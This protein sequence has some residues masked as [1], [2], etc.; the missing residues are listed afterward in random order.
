MEN[1]STLHGLGGS[2]G[3]LGKLLG[4]HPS[5][6]RSRWGRP[7]GFTL[8]ELL[9]VIAI[10]AI[11]AAMLLPVLNKA[12]AK[13]QS[14]T[15]LNNL[16][17]LQLAWLMYCEDSNDL[18]PLNSSRGGHGVAQNR[19]GSWVV[20]NAPRSANV[21]SITQGTL[22]PQ[23]Q[24]PGSYRCPADRS[25]ILTNQ[26]LRRLR[27][28]SI[29]SWLAADLE[30]LGSYVPPASQPEAKTRLGQITDPAQV[31]AFMD[32]SERS[33]DDGVFITAYAKY[34][35]E[36]WGDLPSVQHDQSTAVSFVDDH[37]ELHRWLT[38]KPFR[39]Y[40]AKPLNASDLQDLR[41]LEDRL[42]K[43]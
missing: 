5:G 13:G 20:G 1:Q 24:S 31:F 8:I 36:L 33:I 18:L 28:Y 16:K 2:R 37:G 41:W 21:D 19:T 42:P 38:P 43:Q 26:S 29:N 40:E 4:L 35:A 23:L 25:S 12:K 39:S 17:Q 11:L 7:G 30:A 10:I 15:C 32:E 9:V 27:T 14:V 6:P 34:T 22:H 3:S